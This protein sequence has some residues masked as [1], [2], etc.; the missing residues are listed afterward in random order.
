MKKKKKKTYQGLETH[1]V[2]SPLISFLCLSIPLLS[3]LSADHLLMLVVG[4]VVVVDSWLNRWRWWCDCGGGGHSGNSC[5][6][7]GH[8]W[9]WLLALWS[10][11][12]V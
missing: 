10:F 6:H 2:S 12:T 3:L 1:H 5:C 7:S 4:R 9:W 11:V 8:G